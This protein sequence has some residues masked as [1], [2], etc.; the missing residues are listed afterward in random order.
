MTND[1]YKNDQVWSSI[2]ISMC[3]LSM[4]ST[5]C[6]RGVKA[7]L[8]CVWRVV[9]LW[10]FLVLFRAVPKV[11]FI[12]FRE[13]TQET[14]IHWERLFFH[15][16]VIYYWFYCSSHNTMMEVELSRSI[17]L[18]TTLV[19]FGITYIFQG[20]HLLGRPWMDHVIYHLYF[21]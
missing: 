18:T 6:A 1:Q 15:Y 17:P 20:G 9:V 11:W 7:I 21:S 19:S 3:C 16:Y 8:I 14:P 12:L 5:W 4:V 13:K 2:T 10:V